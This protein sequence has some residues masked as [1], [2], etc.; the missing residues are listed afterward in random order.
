M[1]TCDGLQITQQL[2]SQEVEWHLM[3]SCWRAI[4]IGKGPEVN[5]RSLGTCGCTKQPKHINIGDGVKC[6]LGTD[7]RVSVNYKIPRVSL[8]YDKIRRVKV[9]VGCK[10]QGVKLGYDKSNE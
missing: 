7:K 2:Q 1:R 10:I 4:S 5:D 6:I 8:G 9:L 3:I